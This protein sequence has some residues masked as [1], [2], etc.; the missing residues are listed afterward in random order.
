MKNQSRQLKRNGERIIYKPI[1]KSDFD[2][3]TY[4]NSGLSSISAEKLIIL[5]IDL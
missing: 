4:L 1:F 3:I 2:Y 5:I